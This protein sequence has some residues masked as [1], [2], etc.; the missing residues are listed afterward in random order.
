MFSAGYRNRWGFP[1]SDVVARWQRPVQRILSTI[2]GGA[3]LMSVTA[4]GV[5]PPIVHRERH[6]HYWSAR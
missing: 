1:K 4:Q 5:A 3:I 2:D 6:R